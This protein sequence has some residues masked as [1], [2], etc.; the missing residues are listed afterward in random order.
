MPQAFVETLFK[1]IRYAI[2]GLRKRPGFTFVAVITLALG[3]GANTAIF[4]VVNAVLLKPLAFKDPDRLVIVWEDAG[5][6]GFPRNTPAPANYL[7]WKSQNRSFEDMAATAPTSFNLTGDGDPERVAAHQVSENFFPLLGVQPL[8]G[9]TFLQEEDREGGNKVVLLSYQ[10]WQTRY[11]GATDIVNRN[12]QMNGEKYTIVGVMPAG[13]QFL[14]KEVRV[15]VP[16]ALDKE[17]QANRGGHYLSVVARLKPDIG[18]AQAQADMSAL[19]PTWPTIIRTKC[20][21]E[22]SVR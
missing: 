10:L 13:F 21:M 11:G 20:L 9:R 7:D 12:I 1:D 16:L 6:V 19:M 22:N 4:S 8:L 14:D 18:V 15:W 5:F 3:I 17:E 2:R